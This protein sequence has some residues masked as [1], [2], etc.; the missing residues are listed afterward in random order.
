[1]KLR[2]IVVLVAFGL[3]ASASADVIYSGIQNIVIQVPF[4]TIELAG[5]DAS[6]D[7]IS[8]GGEVFG[9]N[10]IIPSAEVALA[11]SLTETL[12]LNFGDPFPTG[13]IFPSGTE[14]ISGPPPSFEG[15][16]DFYAAMLFGTF[17]GGPMYEGWIQLDM[18]NNG[19]P[20]ASL[21]VVDWAYANV[22][23]ETITMGEGESVSEVP[24][25]SLVYLGSFLSLCL[26]AG[27][28][29]RA[30]IRRS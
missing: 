29:W 27:S 12:R 25:P 11:S 23:G 1:M 14:I 13:A 15:D 4:E 17:G 7:T 22:V 5:V 24:E 2:P 8:L 6:W 10:N 30:S 28:R 16:G 19:T 20:E 21:T 18:Q 26:V 9:G 3:T